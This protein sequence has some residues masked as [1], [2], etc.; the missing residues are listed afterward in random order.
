MIQQLTHDEKPYTF[1]FKDLAEF[2]LGGIT[3]YSTVVVEPGKI[4]YVWFDKD[5]ECLRAPRENVSFHC[6]T[7]AS[8]SWML[9]SI[10]GLSVSTTQC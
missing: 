1:R 4:D 3:G 2:S 9:K 5:G 10:V 7:P 8:F 6:P